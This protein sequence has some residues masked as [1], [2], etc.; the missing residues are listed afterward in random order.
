[1]R[2]RKVEDIVTVLRMRIQGRVYG[3][4]ERLPVERD[5]APELRVA[6]STLRQALATLM[7]EGYLIRRLG[8]KGGWFVTDLAQPMAEWTEAAHTNL[9][10]VRDII[11]Y[12]IA[13]ETTVAQ[14]AAVRCS[15]HQLAVLAASIDDFLHVLPT[16]ADGPIGREA[17]DRLR[18][19]DDRFHKLIAEAADSPMLEEAVKVARA[20][21]FATETRSTYRELA[22]GLPI[23]HQ[24]VLDAIARR[25]PEAARAA[26]QE[27]IE[28][29]ANVWLAAT[30]PAR[31]EA[32]QLSREPVVFGDAQE[33]SEGL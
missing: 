20:E 28:H 27:H 22:A 13:V 23:D 1:M 21:L 16:G 4:G 32:G 15:E 5:L 30:N 17:S 19:I 3:P 12:R 31:A 14:L 6:R 25:D 24:R 7:D 9:R 33:A 2:P 8:V 18:A 29:G 26:M 11:D 10:K